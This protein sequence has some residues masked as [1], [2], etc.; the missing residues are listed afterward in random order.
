[1]LHVAW[2][3]SEPCRMYQR[4]PPIAS[5]STRARAGF[6]TLGCWLSLWHALAWHGLHPWASGRE[7]CWMQHTSWRVAHRLRMINQVCNSHIL[8]YSRW[9]QH[10]RSST[11]FTH[12][13]ISQQS[14][15]QHLISARKSWHCIGLG[16]PW[17]SMRCPEAAIYVS[18]WHVI[19]VDIQIMSGCFSSP[20]WSPLKRDW[21]LAVRWSSV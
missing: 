3:V 9:R 1:M 15:L 6:S 16:G 4:S 13:N 7:E 18:W 12:H 10:E 21:N 20:G 5:A 11:G 19:F 2:N 14:E 17:E 8:S